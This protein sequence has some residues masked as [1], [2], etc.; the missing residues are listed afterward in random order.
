MSA[1]DGRP[2]Y[3]SLVVF[4]DE[5]GDWAMYIDQEIIGYAPTKEDGQH[6]VDMQVFALLKHLPASSISTTPPT[7]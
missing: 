4:D 6:R 3:H 2:H 7:I 1:P 5:T